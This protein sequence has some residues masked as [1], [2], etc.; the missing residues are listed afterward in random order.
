MCRTSPNSGTSAE[1]S[2]GTNDLDLL[3][4]AAIRAVQEHTQS[5][6]EM[7]MKFCKILSCSTTTD[8]S[9][10]NVG[11]DDRQQQYY[12]A[13]IGTSADRLIKLGRSLE[14]LVDMYHTTASDERGEESEKR[15]KKLQDSLQRIAADICLLASMAEHKGTTSDSTTETKSHSLSFHVPRVAFGKTKLQMP[16]VTL[17][18]MR[19][20]Q[21]WGPRIQHLNDGPVGGDCQDNLLRILKRAIIH[22]GMVHI[23]T[24]RFY[25]CSELQIGVALQQLFWTNQVQRRDLILQTKVPAQADPA[26]FRRMLQESFAALQL[27]EHEESY[28]DLFAFHGLNFE[29]HLEYIF[30]TSNNK[31]EDSNETA[32]NCMQVV[33]EY[34]QAGK[35]RHV[36]F[37]THGATSLIY[38]AIATNQFDY[39]N[40]HYHYFGSYTAS[41]DGKHSSSASG[42]EDTAP[43]YPGNLDCIKLAS[44]LNM[45]IFIISP[46]DKGGKLY[47]PSRR[48]RDL[49]LPEME[50]MEFGSQWIWNH[51]DLVRDDDDDKDDGKIN[52]LQLHTYTVG[53]ARPSDL[54]EPALAAFHFKTKQSETLQR[55]QSVVQRL[56]AQKLDA[57]GEDWIKSWWKGLTKARDLSNQQD[58]NPNVHFIEHGQIIWLYNT[59]KAFGMYEF[60]KD[61]YNSFQSNA[62][63]WDKDKSPEENIQAIPK[64]AWGFVPG[65]PLLVDQEHGG[66]DGDKGDNVD[67]FQNDLKAVPPEN[68]ARIREAHEF[69]LK[70]LVQ[71]TTA[72]SSTTTTT[73]KKDA[74]EEDGKK[75]GNS[76]CIPNEWETALDLRTWPDFPDQPSRAPK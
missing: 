22:Y 71:S 12:R 38:K 47:T 2:N 34:V 40:I 60:C 19:F 43:K 58:D 4:Q 27:D 31:S 17:G 54:D 72:S 76:E 1:T 73:D 15:K 62:K 25:G 68:R 67:Y 33:Q 14:N 21:E 63:K 56:E 66:G 75:K 13:F 11:G 5:H 32:I 44:R 46:F 42:E 53:A 61:R 30:G 20:Q 50:P 7:G 49:C 59:L 74:T 24:A 41:G 18:C 23:E 35:I 9:S 55:V 64:M 28:L 8:N 37:S 16:I 36:G 10:K 65:L 29:E 45:G 6:M 26:V 48:L 51:H 57:L 69:I 3:S 52:K 39:V 70:W